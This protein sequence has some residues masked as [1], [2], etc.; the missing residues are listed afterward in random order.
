MYVR[1]SDS[2][3]FRTYELTISKFIGSWSWSVPLV[4][5]SMRLWTHGPSYVHRKDKEPMQ[6]WKRCHL[7]K[8]QSKQQHQ[9]HNWYELPLQISYLVSNTLCFVSLTYWNCRIRST[10][11]LFFNSG[12]I[13][14][15]TFLGMCTILY[16]VL[17]LHFLLSHADTDIFYPGF[18]LISILLHEFKKFSFIV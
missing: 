12:E 15:P 3:Y 13:I 5:F 2:H 10:I 11:W 7:A 14:Y 9:I 18:S 4:F 6:N 16:Y 1:R 17:L 8:F